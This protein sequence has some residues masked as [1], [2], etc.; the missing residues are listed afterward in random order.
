MNNILDRDEDVDMSDYDDYDSWEEFDFS[1]KNPEK[2]EFFKANGISY[3]DYK[4]ADEK[5]KAAYTWAYNNPEKYAVSKLITDDVVKYR[6][7][8]SDLYDIRADKDAYGE[9][10]TGTG[11]QKKI[12]YINSL[13]LGYEQKLLLYKS[14]FKTDDTYN[15]EI[16]N[17]LN[18]LGNLTYEERV[19]IF[20]ELGFTVKDGYV[21][22]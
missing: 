5:G 7:Y 13:D 18:N 2:Y 6:S 14:Q 8:T 3:E 1:E 4:N 10:I 17:Y 11:K 16:I 9:T 19:A 12:A 20:Q 22:W 21:Y 15:T